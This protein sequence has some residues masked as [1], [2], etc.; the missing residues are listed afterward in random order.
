MAFLG[1]DSQSRAHGA[2]VIE[3]LCK[4]GIDLSGS[5]SNPSGE[6]A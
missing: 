3:A 6:R 1:Y 2:K 5:I 4:E